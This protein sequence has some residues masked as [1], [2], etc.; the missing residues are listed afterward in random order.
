MSFC[1]NILEVSS[2]KPRVQVE[3]SGGVQGGRG[4]AE[5]DVQRTVPVEKALN[6]VITR[7]RAAPS[8]NPS[9][10]SQ[11][12]NRSGAL[13]RRRCMQASHA[14]SSEEELVLAGPD[15]WTASS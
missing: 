11:S 2:T 3:S 7:P 8:R 14:A 4:R 5:E 9:L 6:R 10:D 1:K 13:L 15:D 12:A